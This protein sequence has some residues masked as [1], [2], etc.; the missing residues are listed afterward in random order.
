MDLVV[1]SFLLLSDGL[2]ESLF[3]QGQFGDE[4]GDG[5][6]EGVV[7]RVIGRRLNSQDDFVL[8]RMRI[9]VAGEQHLRVF[10]QLTTDHVAQSVVLLVDGEDGRIG[11]FG[12]LLFGNLLLAFEEQKRF[13]CR[14]SVHRQQF[15]LGLE[16][17]DR[18]RELKNDASLQT[19]PR[20][21][22]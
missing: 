9:F 17:C 2:F 16:K 10:Q 15:C 4:I 13:E 7:R 19:F 5:V 18:I 8:Q 1:S 21:V 3:E 20:Q 14:R 11:H 12:V 22:S 6:H